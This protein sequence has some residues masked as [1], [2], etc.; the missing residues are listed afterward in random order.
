MPSQHGQDDWVLSQIDKGFFV[1]VGA[2]DGCLLSNTDKL[3]KLGWNGI[4]IE[5]HPVSYQTLLKNRKCICVDSLIDGKVRIVDFLVGNTGDPGCCIIDEDTDYND[6]RSE[7]IG[8][9]SI[10][11]ATTTLELVL[12]KYKA[13]KVIDYLSVDVE[14]AESRILKNFPFDKYQFKLMTIERPKPEL[15]QKI[16]ELGYEGYGYMLVGEMATDFFYINRNLT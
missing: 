1:E 11:M 8:N 12:N 13:P 16:L 6:G 2:H 15:H 7:W 9:E 14:G 10:S 3:E 5:P 4:C